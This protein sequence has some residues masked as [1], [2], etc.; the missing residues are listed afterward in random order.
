M[1]FETEDLPDRLDWDVE[2]ES[3]RSGDGEWKIR[4][5]SFD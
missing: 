3:L 5:E 4:L 2:I 1:W